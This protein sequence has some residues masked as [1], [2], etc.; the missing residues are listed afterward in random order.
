MI[1]KRHT[2]SGR[3]YYHYRY[4]NITHQL[5]WHTQNPCAHR[6]TE[7]VIHSRAIW[8]ESHTHCP[9]CGHCCTVNCLCT[10]YCAIIEYVSHSIER[11]RASRSSHTSIQSMQISE[12]LRLS[13][14]CARFSCAHS[15]R[16]LCEKPPPPSLCSA[17]R[18]CVFAEYTQH[19]RCCCRRCA[20]CKRC[21]ALAHTT[22]KLHCLVRTTYIRTY[23]VAQIIPL[24]IIGLFQSRARPATGDIYTRALARTIDHHTQTN[25]RLCRHTHTHTAAMVQ[26]SIGQIFNFAHCVHYIVFVYVYIRI[27]CILHYAPQ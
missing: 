22:H 8:C 2:E 9:L 23:M 24:N 7:C 21:K 12:Y 5:M 25:T 27:V 4:Y 16:I 6:H 20:F 18:V 1:T 3:H 17:L 19:H 14:A 11:S 10:T 15:R 26:I 13:H